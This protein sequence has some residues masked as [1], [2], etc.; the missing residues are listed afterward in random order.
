MMTTSVVSLM[1]AMVC[2]RL[3]GEENITLAGTLSYVS[4]LS[5]C[6]GAY[7]VWSAK[8]MYAKTH[9]MSMHSHFAMMAI[10]GIICFGFLS[11]WV[12]NPVDGTIRKNQDWQDR[13]ILLGKGTVSLAFTSML[14]GSFEL[15][16]SWAF[17]FFWWSS[18]CLMLPFLV[19]PW[20]K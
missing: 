19:L 7:V 10:T 11:F 2:Q 12:F 5:M 8:E 18:L 20:R 16:R 13:L 9:L 3:G 17:L 4:M 15:E 6:L 1:G 14:A